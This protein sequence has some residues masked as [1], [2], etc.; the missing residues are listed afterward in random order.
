MAEWKCENC[1][2]MLNGE[3]PPEQCPSCKKKCEFIDIS[4]YIPQCG[5][6]GTDN[7]LR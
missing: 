5:K 7:R 4:C 2:Y 3:K 1:G 6:Q